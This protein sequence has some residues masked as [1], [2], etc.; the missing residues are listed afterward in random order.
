MYHW[1][2]IGTKRIVKK[3]A[4]VVL[5]FA[6]LLNIAGCS[7]GNSISNQ[8]TEPENKRD[9]VATNGVVAAAHPLAAKAG[10][11]IL[12]KGGN[13]FDA[14]V[15]TAF[16]L[17]VVEPHASGLGGGGFA[18]IY[19]AKDQKSYVVDFREVAPAKGNADIYP[20]DDKGKVLNDAMGTGWYAAGVPGE[21]AGLEYINKTFGTM[22]WENLV[23]PAIKQSEEGIVVSETLS[24][25]VTDEFDRAQKFPSQEFYQK[26]FLKNG[27]P[28][29]PGDK[30][31]NPEYTK[32]LQKVAAGGAD[33]FYKGEIA[34]AI[35]SAYAKNGNGFITKDDLANYKVAVHEP[36][37]ANYRGYTVET[38]PPPSSGGLTVLE[39]LNILEGYDLAKMGWG[40]PDYLHT[41]IETQKLA[42]ADRAKYMGDPAFVKVPVSGLLD[43]RYADELRKRINP[44]SASK[45]A[46]K[47]GNPNPYE[48]GSTTSFSVIDKDG[49]M[50]TITKTINHFLG[51]GV[52]PEGTGIMMNDEMLDFTDKI[53]HIN[54]PEPGKR[55]LSS[56]SPVIVLKDGKPF[57]TMGSPG[58]TRII[59]AVTNVLVNTIDFGMD[60]QA[61]IVAARYHNPNAKATDIESA[62]ASETIKALEEKGH[63]FKLR[64]SMDLFFGGVQGV[65]IGPD[66]KL[67]GGADPRRDGVAV[68]Y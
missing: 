15:V 64:D 25:I 37:R 20:R 58:G 53:G 9:V 10:L 40:T 7:S 54:S 35:A 27:L 30:V 56:I 19:S 33:A 67:H 60:L 11:E 29:Q 3:I 4:G 6:M 57:M 59:P 66:G 16:M 5:S 18:T 43:K 23:N 44:Q 42:F 31:V 61:A 47:A 8:L 68:G 38:V 17:G 41:F 14:A 12:K 2:E 55:P 28:V 48:S 52:V 1:G 49:N 39:M 50:I 63:K 22:K 36:I 62:V 46:V 13:A 51:S 24:K 65:M 32:S 34:D 26:T 21:V 45:Q